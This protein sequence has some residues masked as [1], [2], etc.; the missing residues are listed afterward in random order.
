M[1]KELKGSVFLLSAALEIVRDNRFNLKVLAQV[2]DVSNF[3]DTKRGSLKMFYAAS[4][5]P[6]IFLDNR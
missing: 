4:K 2:E 3:R 6:P 5:G 1:E